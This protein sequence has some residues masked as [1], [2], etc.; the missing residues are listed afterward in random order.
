[1]ENPVYY[2]QYAYARISSIGRVAKS[3]AS[4]ASRSTEADLGVLDSERETE[5]LRCLEE[6][7][8]IIAEAARDRAPHKVT[9][10]VRRLA[11]I[12]PRLLPRLPRALRG[13]RRHG[14]PGATLARRGRPRRHLRR[15][16]R[17]R[18]E[19]SRIH[20][21]P[22]IRRDPGVPDEGPVDPA[23]LPDNAEVV[24]GE[25]LRVAGVDLVELAEAH[26]TPLF[27]YDEEHMRTAMPRGEER[28]GR[29]CRVRD[30]GLPV[31][32]DG[33]SR[34]RRGA[35]PGRVDRRRAARRARRRRST[36]DDRL[37]RQQ[38]G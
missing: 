37:S 1:M 7:P 26:G 31:P 10:W 34:L 13:C 15:A 8:D 6:L 2:V 9:A 17:A 22:A 30:E 35:L 32:S 12:L 23:L 25:A 16:R 28:V 24:P 29:R 19:R 38:Q 33:A 18:P 36:A 27:V 11:G 4:S 5:L 20:V 3:A 21:S 14:P